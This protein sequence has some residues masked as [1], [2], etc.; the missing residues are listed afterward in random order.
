MLNITTRGDYIVLTDE[1]S[2]LIGGVNN[3]GIVNAL[4]ASAVLRHIVGI[5][6]AENPLVGDF[7]GD[8]TINALDASAILKTLTD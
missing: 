8:G 7:N 3:D 4:D 2:A 1:Y 5:E 6:D